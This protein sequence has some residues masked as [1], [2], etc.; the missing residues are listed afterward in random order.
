ME[1]QYKACCKGVR[2]QIKEMSM[3]GSGI[4]DTGRV[5]GIDKNTVVNTLKKTKLVSLITRR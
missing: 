4:R 3:N 5:L 2:E 1:Y